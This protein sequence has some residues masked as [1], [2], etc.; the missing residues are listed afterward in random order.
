MNVQADIS[1]RNYRTTEKKKD[2]QRKDRLPTE[3]SKY[4][5]TFP[6]SKKMLNRI[7]FLKF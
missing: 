2:N 1:K 5:L 7:V 3:E 4:I 6:N